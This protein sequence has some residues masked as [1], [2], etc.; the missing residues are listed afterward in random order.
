MK[1][2]KGKLAA[3]LVWAAKGSS[4]GFRGLGAT[5]AEEMH[6]MGIA[7]D[8]GFGCAT[9]YDLETEALKVADAI[10]ARYLESLEPA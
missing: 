3:D 7:C 5:V 9:H 10:R 1:T 2:T 6:L 4:A 8:I